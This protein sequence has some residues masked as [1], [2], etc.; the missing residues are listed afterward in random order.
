MIHKSNDY[1]DFF[2]GD[3]KSGRKKLWVNISKVSSRFELSC[4][5]TQYLP[6]VTWNAPKSMWR[7]YIA[8]DGICILSQNRSNFRFF[9]RNAQVF[10]DKIP[11]MPNFSNLILGHFK[12]PPVFSFFC[13]KSISQNVFIT[14]ILKICPKNHVAVRKFFEWQKWPTWFI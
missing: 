2:V 5:R 7:I 13:R 12:K 10:I 6:G 11:E 3:E 1:C 9:S 4:H 8:R 14:I